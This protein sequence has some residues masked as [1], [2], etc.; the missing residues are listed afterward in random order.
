M[1]KLILIGMIVAAANANQIKCDYNWD[2]L[3]E[4]KAKLP[5][6]IK[7]R[8]VNELKLT[9]RYMYK[10]SSA[11]VVNCEEGGAREKEALFYID[12]IKA[13]VKKFNLK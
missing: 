3:M 12:H 8:L 5:K 9:Y 4:H 10:Y 11:V 1:R 6:I 2:K 13:Q 7:Y